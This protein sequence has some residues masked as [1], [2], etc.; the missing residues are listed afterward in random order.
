VVLTFDIFISLQITNVII[1]KMENTENYLRCYKMTYDT[2]FAPNPYHGVLT[3]ATCKPDIRRNAKEGEWIAGFTAK[4]VFDKNGIKHTGFEK[5]HKLIYLAKVKYI[6]TLGEYWECDK[7]KNKRP[8]NS[9]QSRNTTKCGCGGSSAKNNIP[10]TGDNIYKMVNGE[11]VQQP[12]GHHNS[13]ETAK[14]DTRGEFVLICKEFYYFGVENA[15]DVSSVFQ[16]A[17]SLPRNYKNFS[18]K[19]GQGLVNFIK[20]EYPQRGIIEKHPQ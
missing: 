15:I 19:E 1:S 8:Q 16:Y 5:N 18:E 12:N 3:L 20:K 17:N 7:Y 14:H 13:K 6:M 10:D 2:G 11:L 4:E 9:A